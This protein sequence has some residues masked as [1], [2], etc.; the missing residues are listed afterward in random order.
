MFGVGARKVEAHILL[1]IPYTTAAVRN[2]TVRENDAHFTAIKNV[3]GTFVIDFIISTCHIPAF[4][5]SIHGLLREVDHL[6]YDFRWC[7]ILGTKT[8]A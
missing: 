8:A 3:M 2:E 5:I 1:V 6:E 4:L 7:P